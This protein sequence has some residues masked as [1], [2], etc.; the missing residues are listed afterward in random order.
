MTT[1]ETEG[2]AAR[3]AAPSRPARVLRGQLPAVAAVALGG[4]AGACARYAATLWWPG[5]EG[6]FPWTVFWVNAAGCAVIGAF[7]T[8]TD[9]W[10]VHPLLRPFF[11]TGV[12]GGFTTFS[13]FTVDVARLVDT[14]HVRTALLYLA[15]TPLLALTAVWLAAT[16]TRRLVRNGRPA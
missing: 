7:L 14:G 13:T 12:L 6:A 15:A 16:A 4:A 2:A 11:G 5:G 1:P 9:V 3:P 10:P 8:L